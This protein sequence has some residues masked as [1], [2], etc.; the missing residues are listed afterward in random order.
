MEFAQKLLPN[1]P[2]LAVMGGFHLLSATPDQV[3]WTG[4]KFKAFGVESVVG[5][6]CTGINPVTDLRNTGGFNRQSMVVG[7]VGATFTLGEG[8]RHGPMTN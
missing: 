5:A 4:E 8:I 6:H 1:R 7:S 2:I 3:K